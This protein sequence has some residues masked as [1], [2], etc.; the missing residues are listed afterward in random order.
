[1]QIIQQSDFSAARLAAAQITEDSV[2]QELR[3][4]LCRLGPHITMDDRRPPANS[5]HA[6]KKCLLTVLRV[7][8][9]LD[10]NLL[11]CDFG[12]RA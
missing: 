3:D 10:Q 12:F 5:L 11:A 1:M 7:P 8:R 4:D 2:R 9:E 6:A